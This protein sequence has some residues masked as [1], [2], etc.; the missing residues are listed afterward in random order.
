MDLFGRTRRRAPAVS[1]EDWQ[2]IEPFIRANYKSM[3][4]GRL[5]DKLREDYGVSLTLRQF[6]YQLPKWGLRK[7]KVARA[8][9]PKPV[10]IPGSPSESTPIPSNLSAYIAH[11]RDSTASVDHDLSSSGSIRSPDANIAV[12]TMGTDESLT[13]GP[14]RVPAEYQQFQLHRPLLSEHT[15]GQNG[16]VSFS[17]PFR[18]RNPIRFNVGSHS[19]C[20]LQSFQPFALLKRH[21]LT[22]HVKPTQH[23]CIRCRANFQS[24]E[25]LSAHMRRPPGEICLVDTTSTEFNDPEDGITLEVADRLRLRGG[26][27]S[28]QTWESLWRVLFPQDEDEHIRPPEFVPLVEVFLFERL[29]LGEVPKLIDHLIKSEL[30]QDFQDEMGEKFGASVR[31]QLQKWYE[32]YKSSQDSEHSAQHLRGEASDL[33]SDEGTNPFLA[34]HVKNN[35][36]EKTSATDKRS[37]RGENQ[38]RCQG[39]LKNGQKWGCEATF[40]RADKLGD[41]FRSKTGQKCVYPLLL[42]QSKDRETSGTEAGGALFADQ[43]GSNA[44]ALQAV[45][46]MILPFEGFLQPCGI[47]VT[48]EDANSQHDMM[49]VFQ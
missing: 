6:N 45:E 3:T 2:R 44:A 19:N 18:K 10:T 4:V 14:A 39:F 30:P 21:V 34:M 35:S 47:G 7:Y 27:G 26:L 23:R 5:L 32:D 1:D 28:I 46:R 16:E 40:A 36:P 43:S 24:P 22:H 17:C 12:D 15:A 11:R 41:H 13:K 38:F 31:A 42:Q 9:T 48:S 37:N 29:L 33:G 20:A 8:E 25:E 49:G